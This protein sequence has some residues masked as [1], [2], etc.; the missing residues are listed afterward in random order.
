MYYPGMIDTIVSNSKMFLY[1]SNC[2]EKDKQD[3]ELRKEMAKQAPKQ[4][5]KRRF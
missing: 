2:L 3:I 1:Q 5:N 4:V